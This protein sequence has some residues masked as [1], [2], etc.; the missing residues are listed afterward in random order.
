VAAGQA[1]ITA[2][3]AAVPAKTASATVEVFNPILITGVTLSPAN[4]ALTKGASGA[5]TPAFTPPNTTDTDLIW[6]SSAPLVA[7]VSGGTVTAVGGG[8][9]VITA[10]AA[11]DSSIS[12]AVTVTVTVPLTG[13]SLS[14]DPLAI[15]GV[16]ATGSFTVQYIPPD[17]T[18]KGVTWSSDAAGVATVSNGTVTAVAGGTAVITAASTANSG[19]QASATVNVT[20]PITGLGLNATTLS[21]PKDG[22]DTL[23]VTYTP[24]GTT[25]TGVIWT[26]SAPS[27]ATVFG[28]TVT[29]VGG[30]TAIITAASAFDSSIR[31]TATVTVTVPLTGLRLPAAGAVGVGKTASLLVEYLPPDA[32]ETGITWTSSAPSVATVHSST[33][34]ITGVAIGTAT[35]TATSTANGSLSAVCAVTVR[36]SGAEATI[37]FESF[38]DET[39]A[40]T[41]T[42]NQGTQLVVAAPA[43]FVR[44]LWFVDGS[45][46]IPWYSESLPTLAIAASPGRHYIT[47]IVEKTD[48]SHFSKTVHYT[49]GY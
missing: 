8:T 30:G 27:V 26:S 49:V 31:D 23:T 28:G 2:T 38:E 22:S 20:I 1:T 16:G 15:S 39:I 44:Y 48:G 19:I 32:T 43:G 10:T 14:P 7:T 24:A 5:L 35:I 46:F 36:A 29:A 9:A 3:S 42:V 11:L 13:I 6:T 40:L 18:E 21:L 4:L 33:G 37:R 41:D 47:V 12:A 25:Q 17:A 45:P 34:V